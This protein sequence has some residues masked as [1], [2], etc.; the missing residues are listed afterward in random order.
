MLSLKQLEALKGEGGGMSRSSGKVDW[1]D[2]CWKEMLVYQRKSAVHTSNRDQIA[3]FYGL[4]PGMTVVDVGC[5]LGFLGSNY[6]SYFGKGGHYIG[7]DLA[8]DLVGHVKDLSAEWAIDGKADFLVGDVYNLPMEDDTADCVICQTLLMH[9]ANPRKALAEMIRVAKSGGVIACQEPD[10]VSALL[11]ARS[12]SLPDEDIADQLR[13]TKVTAL[14]NRG[15]I[16]LGLGDASIGAKVYALMKQQRL[17]DVDVKTSDYVPHL[18]PPYDDE[19]EQV[20]LDF[21][22]K[23]SLDD[24][25]QA[26]LRERDKT[27][28]LAGGGDREEWERYRTCSDKVIAEMR[29][30]V[31]EG[32]YHFCGVYPMYFTRGFKAKA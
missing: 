31:E 23:G 8:S 1:T 10:N 14:I 3:D 18:Y 20:Q 24:S 29:R 2:N 13:R 5:G 11:T 32:S 21:V 15:R 28:F 17:V 4:H 25:R 12:W 30:Q 27:A 9:L 26:T 19:Q 22:R 16:K 7:I 6:W